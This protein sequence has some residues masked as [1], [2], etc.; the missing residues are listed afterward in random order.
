[1]EPDIVPEAVIREV[2]GGRAKLRAEYA[3]AQQE[4]EK[5]RCEFLEAAGRLEA[6]SSQL[7]RKSE[8]LRHL[9]GLQTRE[10]LEIVCIAR[11]PRSANWKRR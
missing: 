7:R 5:I 2:I 10:M 11:T 9:S 3:D 4:L 8:E 6:A 1:M